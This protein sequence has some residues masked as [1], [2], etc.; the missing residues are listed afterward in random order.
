MECAHKIGL[1][2]SATMMYGTVEIEEQQARHM[3]K[4]ARLHK[5][6]ENLWRL[7]PGVLN[8]LEHRYNQKDQ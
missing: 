5:K 1:K 6:Q 3:M 7:F 8:L 2:A 4:I